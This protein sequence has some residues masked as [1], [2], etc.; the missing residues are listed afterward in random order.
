MK[1]YKGNMSVS[2]YYYGSVAKFW[3][4][5]GHEMTGSDTAT[6]QQTGNWSSP[7]PTCLSLAGYLRLSHRHRRFVVGSVVVVHISRFLVYY[8]S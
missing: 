7:S 5:S 8:N 3:C 2:G 1:P 4:L 6:C